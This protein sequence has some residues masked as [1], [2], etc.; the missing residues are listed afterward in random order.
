MTMLDGRMTHAWIESCE[1]LP[2]A[3]AVYPWKSAPVSIPISKLTRPP[4]PSSTA[5]TVQIA[6]AQPRL[7]LALDPSATAPVDLTRRCDADDP[8]NQVPKGRL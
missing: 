6:M 4:C 5:S 7:A 3:V 8:T 1:R 2:F